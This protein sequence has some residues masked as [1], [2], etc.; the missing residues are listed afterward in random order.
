ML[1]RD[2]R[3]VRLLARR[4]AQRGA[5]Q[6]RAGCGRRPPCRRRRL[7]AG[8]VPVRRSGGASEARAHR[9]RPRLE[10]SRRP[11]PVRRERVG[12]E[13]VPAASCWPWPR[14]LRERCSWGACPLE[15]LDPD[16]WRARVA[17]LPQR[18]Y[19][20]PRADVRPPCG[21]PSRP[22]A[23]SGS[24]R[25]SSGWASCRP[26]ARRRRPARRSRVDSLSVG[27][28][29]ARRARAAHVPGRGAVSPRR[30]R[31]E[32]RSRRASSS[33]RS[34]CA[35]S[36]G[37]RWSP[38]PR[39]RRSC[40]RSAD[41]VVVLEGGTDRRDGRERPRRRRDPSRLP[42][43]PGARTAR[44]LSTATSSASPAGDRA[45]RELAAGAFF[46]RA[47]H[48]ASRTAL[49]DSDKRPGPGRILRSRDLPVLELTEPAR[50]DLDPTACSSAS[51]SLPMS[52]LRPS[53]TRPQLRSRV[54]STPSRISRSIWT[55]MSVGLSIGS[56]VQSARGNGATASGLRLSQA[57]DS[58]LYL[59]QS[60]PS[61]SSIASNGSARTPQ[62]PLHVPTSSQFGPSSRSTS[63]VFAF[64]STS[65]A[66]RTPSRA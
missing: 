18:P 2:E 6:G 22:R 41:R 40:S 66:C 46:A 31:R 60:T 13:H 27:R 15:D 32:P 35:S 9:G 3:W 49:G 26:A 50:F 33:W 10:R 30:A 37:G 19:L 16:A 64:G 43:R 63:S 34:F 23:T 14:R 25:R 65:H 38:S 58:P 54:W 61:S 62:S 42:A 24:C 7:R 44:H 1:V 21:G 55:V 53:R 8:V 29:P 4:G 56:H 12:Q 51:L 45:T 11:R 57:E 52:A 59:A 47:R 20:P 36:P 17:F 28:A 48:A 5:R 39:T